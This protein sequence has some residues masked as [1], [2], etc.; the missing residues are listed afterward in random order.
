M[1]G[2][3]MRVMELHGKIKDPEPFILDFVPKETRER[4]KGQQS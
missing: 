4:D 2:Y 1:K 3:I